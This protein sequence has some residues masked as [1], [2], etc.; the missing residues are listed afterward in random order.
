MPDPQKPRKAQKV[1]QSTIDSMKTMGMTKAIQ[2][3]NSGTASAEF[4]EGAKRMYG[5]RVNPS[6]A[7]TKSN[8]APLTDRSPV[9]KP[10]VTPASSVGAPP[11]TAAPKKVDPK[12]EAY[13]KS[14]AA[15]KKMP[16]QFKKNE[17]AM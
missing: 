15:I 2:K 11:V 16:K 7:A 13:D 8:A 17:S 10:K 4:I 1:S 6:A 14:Q 12:K 5:S 3:A 9:V